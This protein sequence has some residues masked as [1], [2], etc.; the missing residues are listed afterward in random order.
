MGDIR[1]AVCEREY[2]EDKKGLTHLFATAP[3]SE[4]CTWKSFGS[5]FLY[6]LLDQIQNRVKCHGDDT[7]DHNRH[8]D[9]GELEGL[10]SV[11]DKISE[12][13]P[14]TD[15]FADDNTHQTETDVDLHDT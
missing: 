9:P 10:T 1:R 15:K 5:A 8:Q 4:K 13:F 11:D 12:T 7:Q 3:F 14:G 6:L 2:I